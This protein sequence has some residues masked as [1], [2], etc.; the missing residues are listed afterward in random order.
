MLD[1]RED[2]T[3]LIRSKLFNILVERAQREPSSR[4]NSN[5][6][7]PPQLPPIEIARTERDRRE[8]PAEERQ[9][10]RDNP[11]KPQPQIFRNG[12]TWSGSQFSPVLNP[13][14]ANLIAMGMN[15]MTSSQQQA[16]GQNTGH[17]QAGGDGSGGMF[18]SRMPMMGMPTMG[19]MG[20]GMGT[21][22]GVGTD[23]GP[24]SPMMID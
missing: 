18:D 6:S 24:V 8:E 22:M 21:G 12:S 17:T 1:P 11:Q 5:G 23:L 13:M 3:P 4:T 7:G 10:H 20:M 2:R 16:F 15:P 9:R 14:I 19:I